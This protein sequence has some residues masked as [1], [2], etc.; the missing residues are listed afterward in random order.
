MPRRHHT[1][2][3]LLSPGYTQVSVQGTTGITFRKVSDA[4][5][6][7]Y[8]RTTEEPSRFKILKSNGIATGSAGAGLFTRRHLLQQDE[9]STFMEISGNGTV[10]LRDVSEQ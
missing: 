4:A 5:I 10:S 8:L 9:P 6:D 2:Y 3:L 1:T 7:W